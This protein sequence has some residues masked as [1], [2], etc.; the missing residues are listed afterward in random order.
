MLSCFLLKN[1]IT[2]ANNIPYT[3]YKNV[4]AYKNLL[5]VVLLFSKK[6][7]VIQNS[8]RISIN[9]SIYIIF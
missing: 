3:D 5:L 7:G 6:Q 8:W 1:C 4:G 2:F 9:I